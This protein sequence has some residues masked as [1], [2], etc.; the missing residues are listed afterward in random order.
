MK[1]VTYFLFGVACHVLFLLTFAYMVCFVGGF[2][3]S[4]TIDG[5]PH[6]ASRGSAHRP[7]SP[8]PVFTQSPR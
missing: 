1:R 8:K 6:E 4:K 5:P 3:V 2:L 7:I